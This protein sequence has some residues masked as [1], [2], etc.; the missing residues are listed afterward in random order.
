MAEK[1]IKKKAAVGSHALPP[2]VVNLQPSS[3]SIKK[4]IAHWVLK[5][6]ALIGII[7]CRMRCVPLTTLPVAECCLS[8]VMYL[9]RKCQL[10]ADELIGA[11]FQEAEIETVVNV[12]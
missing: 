10:N 7:N 2:F 11:A 3:E 4:H 5:V 12:A 1:V 9:G 6:C 8:A